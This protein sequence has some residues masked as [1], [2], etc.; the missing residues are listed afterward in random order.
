MMRPFDRCFCVQIISFQRISWRPDICLEQICTG[1]M[2][3]K[4]WY[5]KDAAYCSDRIS[6]LSNRLDIYILS[7]HQRFSAKSSWLQPNQVLWCV[8][9]TLINLYT[10]C[11]RICSDLSSDAIAYNLSTKILI[12]HTDTNT[13]QLC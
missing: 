5:C 13:V 9:G 11:Q 7:R 8:T 10:S 3:Y 1:Q 12:T 2:T 6:G 4:N